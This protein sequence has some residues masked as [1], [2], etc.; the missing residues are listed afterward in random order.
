MKKLLIFFIGISI[1]TCSLYSQNKAI[2]GRVITDDFQTVPGVLITVNDTVKVGTTDLNGF[3][4]IDI[5][6]E[7]PRGRAVG[8]SKQTQLVFVQLRVF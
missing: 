3:F 8:V 7:L 6:N 5:P 1:T 2:K 4:K